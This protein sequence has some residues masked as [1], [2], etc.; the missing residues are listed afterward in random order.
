[1]SRRKKKDEHHVDE[2]WLLPY[3]DLLT[4]LLALFIV[5]FAMS[6][7]DTQKY[8]ELSQVFSNEFS[9]GQGILEEKD[10]TEQPLPA[11]QP[12]QEKEKSKNEQEKNSAMEKEQLQKVKENINAY[13]KKKNLTDVLQ[14][15][16]S[17]EGLLITIS[18]DFSFHSGSA[19]VNREGKKIAKEISG[20][21]LTDPPHQIIVS[22]H[23]DDLPIHNEEFSSNWELS[24][25]RAIHFMRIILENE[26]LDPTKF[27]AKGFGEYKPAVPN[28]S[29]A[30]RAANR[31]VEVLI[32]PNYNLQ[33]G[34]QNKN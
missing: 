2:S 20:F 27:S 7:V 15:Q 3:S 21:L 16:L 31:R 18:N 25:M 22:G 23:A 11:P 12:E 24:V 8:K 17:D 29:E 5:L 32:L 33:T 13:I 4:L 1:M 9:G 34:E 30:N 26:Q 14:T 19:D 28:T 6:E 10:P